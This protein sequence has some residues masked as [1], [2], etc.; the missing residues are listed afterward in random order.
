MCRGFDRVWAEVEIIRGTKAEGVWAE[1]DRVWAEVDR[2]W[3]EEEDFRGTEA[4]GVVGV[5][6]S[7]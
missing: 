3:A 1:V 6:K 5:G 4:E 7:T 2:V